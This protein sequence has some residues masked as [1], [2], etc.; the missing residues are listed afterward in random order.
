MSPRVSQLDMSAVVEWTSS[1]CPPSGT[2]AGLLWIWGPCPPCI[3]PP[4]AQSAGDA[5]NQQQDGMTEHPCADKPADGCNP[6]LKIQG[7]PARHDQYA[8]AQQHDQCRRR[9]GGN[10]CA[11][12]DSAMQAH[13]T[14]HQATIG[15]ADRDGD[16]QPDVRSG[17]RQ[18]EQPEQCVEHQYLVREAGCRVHGIAFPEGHRLMCGRAGGFSSIWRQQSATIERERRSLTPASLHLRAAG[19]FPS[20]G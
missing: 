15:G 10:V 20:G 4:S 19:G 6:E 11:A 3:L 16:C 8:A 1:A 18:E 7:Y 9:E 17:L 14:R 12:A 13:G 5:G 2:G